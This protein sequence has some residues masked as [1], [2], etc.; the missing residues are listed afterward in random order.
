M[1]TKKGYK[2]IAEFS[3][4]PVGEGTSVSRYVKVAMRELRKAKGIRL[5][6]T[7]MA[8]V[9]EA[10]KISEIFKAVEAAH[11]ALFK[12]GAMRVDFILRVDDRRDKQRRME[13]KVAAV[14]EPE[15]P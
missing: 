2:V 15:I 9:V 1:E 4:H 11:E 12:E 8:T 3:I 5:M 10:D 6:V 13:D 14:S 7:P